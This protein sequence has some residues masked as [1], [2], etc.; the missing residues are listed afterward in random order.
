ML[1][2]C[3]PLLG[4]IGLTQA[5]GIS[6]AF[7]TSKAIKSGWYKRLKQPDWQPPSNVF[8]PVWT[9][10]Y[11]TMAIAAWRIWRKRDE[12]PDA[13]KTALTLWGSQLALNAA[14]SWLFFGA[15]KPKLALAE[16]IALWAAIAATATAF[17]R[18]DRTA[19][20]LLWPYLAWVSFA[21]ALNATIAAR[22]EE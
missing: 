7:P 8:A 18:I 14:W 9:I 10:L 20:A 2:K 19:S 15:R 21:S 13:V 16:I 11:L 1:K 22:N 12:E 17:W 4:F 3:A 6:G 5:V